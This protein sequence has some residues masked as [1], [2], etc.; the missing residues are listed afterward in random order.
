MGILHKAV[1]LEDGLPILLILAV[2]G[3]FTKELLYS[4]LV[5]VVVLEYEVIKVS[6]LEVFLE[7]NINE[8]LA[9]PLRLRTCL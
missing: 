3:I 1:V 4:D 6:C 5:A 8:A 9:W 2:V 7:F